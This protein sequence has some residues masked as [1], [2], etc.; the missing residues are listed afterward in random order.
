M[1][2]IRII[3]SNGVTYTID[4]DLSIGNGGEGTVS[5]LNNGYVVKL[6]HNKTDA[7]PQN[8]IDELSPLDDNLFIKPLLT[9][10][11]DANG[12]IMKEL[13][14]SEYFPI[15]SL[16][17]LSFANKNGFPNDYKKRISEKLIKGVKNAHDN[18]IVIGDLNPFN[19]MVNSKLDVKFIDVDSYQTK[20]FRHNDKL[21]ED[22]RDY[23]YNGL[24]SK[25]S[26]YFALSVIIFNLLTGIHPYKGIHKVYRD[27]LKDREINNI[28][29]LNTIEIKNIKIPKFYIPIKD[30]L[31]NDL[32]YD[33]YQNNRRFLI[34]L[35]G[36][37]VDNIKFDAVVMSNDLLIKDL[38]NG[39]IFNV[40]SSNKFIAVYAEDYV[41]LY[42][43]EGRG[44]IMNYG[45]I[46]SHSK[47]VLTDRY[48]FIFKKINNPSGY[49]LQ[50]YDGKNFIDC[51]SPIFSN[52]HVIN[53]YENI[54]V[55]I[56]KDNKMFKLYLDELFLNQY[57]YEVSD[58]YHKSV[59][60]L[61]S[62]IQNFSN[63]TNIF[64]NSNGKLL[65]YVI[66]EKIIDIIQNRNTGIYTV[67]ENNKI[68]HKLFSINQYGNIKVKNIDE[69]YPYTYNGKLIII[70]NDDKLHFIDSETLN[71]IVSFET[72]GLDN[73]QILSTNGGILTFNNKKVQVLNTK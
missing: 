45:V 47:V 55:I 5:S 7:I 2:K 71:E 62:L 30:K 70:Y 59:R 50:L 34:S 73:N 58:I 23:Y 43:C 12:Y 72:S 48:V 17:S 61:Q 18:G 14:L 41:H 6:Y 64:Y 51:P 66:N 38:F 31:L 29:L 1:E 57:R 68:V 4:S 67:I 36:K 26:D 37:Q 11:G 35:D 20:S 9:V 3:D 25:E 46:D 49:I 24:V 33:I 53:Q 10:H 22:I 40:V 60:T 56:T 54:L 65:Q 69:V 13:N 15:Y 39:N 32:F 8:K 19:I 52:I 28:S 63:K 44:I 21:L 27:K 42:K 16:Y